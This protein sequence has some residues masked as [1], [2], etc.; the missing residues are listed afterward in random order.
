MLSD[1]D[2]GT[3]TLEGMRSRNHPGVHELSFYLNFELKNIKY[4][5]IQIYMKISQ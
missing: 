2:F 1:Q 3:G 4:N 5:D